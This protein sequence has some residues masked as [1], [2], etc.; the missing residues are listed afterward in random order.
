MS[1]D[2]YI[3]DIQGH[4]QNFDVFKRN[5]RLYIQLLTESEP[6]EWTYESFLNRAIELLCDVDPINVEQN[7]QKFKRK[8]K[9]QIPVEFYGDYFRV[10]TRLH[11]TLKALR[12]GSGGFRRSQ[13]RQIAGGRVKGEYIDKLLSCLLRQGKA[14]LTKDKK[15]CYTV[16]TK[17]TRKRQLAG[18]NTHRMRIGRR[19]DKINASES[20]SIAHHGN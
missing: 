8:M 15:Y 3:A 10:L 6:V 12:E 7:L 9:D 4:T 13:I 5:G 16:R 14:H 20:R 18:S 17:T 11:Y 2:L 1:N 19:A